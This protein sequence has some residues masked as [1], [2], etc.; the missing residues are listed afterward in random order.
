LISITPIIPVTDID[1]AVSF[2]T[3]T[4][5][6]EAGLHV[7]DYAYV[8][9]D[10]VALRLVKAPPDADMRHDEARQMS[11]YIDVD[12]VD[13]L[14]ASMASGLN[15]LPKAHVRAPFDQPYGQR[16]FHVIYEALLIFFGAPILTGEPA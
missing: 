15:T 1:A 10:A 6:F 14:F 5:G 7:S 2:F 9:R 12:D 11:C 3:G 13:A 4:L 8:R 16:E